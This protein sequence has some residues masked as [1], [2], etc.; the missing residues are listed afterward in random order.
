MM[1]NR[2]KTANKNNE[3]TIDFPG[4]RG[5]KKNKINVFQWNNKFESWKY[6]SLIK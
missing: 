1:K 3:S 4:K 2:E 6:V 5:G